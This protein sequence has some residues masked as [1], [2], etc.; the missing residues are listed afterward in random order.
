L[1]NILK[2]RLLTVDVIKEAVLSPGL[3]DPDTD[4]EVVQ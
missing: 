4:G 2:E 1:L 3:N